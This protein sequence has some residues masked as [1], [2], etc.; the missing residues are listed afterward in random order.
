L[1]LLM[2]AVVRSIFWLGAAYMVIKPGV[3]LPDANALAAQAM[4]AGTQVVVSQV[5]AIECDSLQC[6]GGKAIFAAAI[7]PSLPA[8]DPMHETT[9]ISSVPYPRP[10]PDWRDS[11]RPPQGA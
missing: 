2:F 3:A 6:I 4:V 9:A 11:G 7:Q 8:A 5:D 1:E 10:R